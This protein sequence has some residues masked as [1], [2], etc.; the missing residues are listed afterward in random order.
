MSKND[1]SDIIDHPHYQSKT[2]PHMSLYDRAAQFAPFSALVGYDAAVDEAGR[3]TDRQ[4]ILDE[5]A[6]TRLDE[7]LRAL[8]ETAPEHPEIKVTCFIKDDKKEGGS[9]VEMTGR[10]KRINNYDNV[11]EFMDGKEIPFSDILEIE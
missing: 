7:S 5:D 9:Y 10:I 1:Y 4:I 6:I 8:S 2:R 11:I 3:L